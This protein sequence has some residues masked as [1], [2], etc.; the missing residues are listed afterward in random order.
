MPDDVQVQANKR[1]LSD[2]IRDVID[3]KNLSAADR[4]LAPNFLHHDLAPGEQT[5]DQ[6]GREGI[7]NFFGSVVFPGL[8][9]FNTTFEDIIGEKDL[10][11]ARWQQSVTQSGVWLGRPPS[12][13]R[14]TIGGISIVRVRYGLIVEEWEV[15]NTAALLL[16]F[17]VIALPKPLEAAVLRT[18]GASAAV[19]VSRVLTGG[20]LAQPGASAVP[21]ASLDQVKAVAGQFISRILNDGNIVLGREKLANKRGDIKMLGGQAAGSIHQIRNFAIE[22]YRVEIARQAQRRGAYNFGRPISPAERNCREE[23]GERAPGRVLEFS[24]ESGIQNDKAPVQRYLKI[25]GVEVA[26]QEAGFKDHPIER[27]KAR[28][29]QVTGL[30]I[31]NRAIGDLPQATDI[32]HAENRLGTEFRMHFRDKDAGIIPKVGP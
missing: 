5:R 28:A 29:N 17:N 10:V 25:A 30:R 16:A 20:P 4:Y 8:S 18:N 13:K 23:L 21:A 31:R 32:I 12:N 24:H 6:T 27:V 14:T 26:V 7:K 1:I 11:A 19:P 2:F 3:S 9:N 22:R 15:R